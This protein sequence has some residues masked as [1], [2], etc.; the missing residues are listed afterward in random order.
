MAVDVIDPDFRHAIGLIDA[1]A[2]EGLAAWLDEHPR[3]LAE[4]VPVA[5]DAAGA[6]F[7]NP[8]LIWFVAENPVRN[9]TLP[10]NISAVVETL[11][12]VARQHGLADLKADLDYTLALVASGRV[13]REA[14][15]QDALIETLTRAGADPDGAVNAALGHR[16]IAAAE[17]L[18]RCGAEMTV[19][20]AAGLDRTAD[21]ARLAVGCDRDALQEALTLA[22]VTGAA[23][24]VSVVVAQGADPKAFNPAHLHAHSTPLHQAVDSGSLATV[25]ALVDAGASIETRDKLF[26]GD[27]LGWARHLGRQEIAD[28]LAALSGQI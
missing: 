9:D 22:A 11:V 1:G 21:V 15:V 2:C 6:Y 4:S 12:A 27:A 26:N 24:V 25:R 14:G 19:Q 18:L 8:K 10:A 23:D 13:A 17:C 7:A 3:L 5:D 20:L 16:E 28:Y